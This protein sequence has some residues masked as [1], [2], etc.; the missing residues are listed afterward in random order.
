MSLMLICVLLPIGQI[1]T[2]DPYC[3]YT[4]AENIIQRLRCGY[5]NPVTILVLGGTPIGIQTE[6]DFSTP[7][8]LYQT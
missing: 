2:I 5:C 6:V 7:P 8:F 1:L 4:P 3:S